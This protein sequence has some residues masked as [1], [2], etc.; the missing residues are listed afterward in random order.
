MVY[1]TGGGNV[2]SPTGGVKINLVPKEGGNRFSGSLFGGYEGSSLQSNNLTPRL[3]AMQVKSVDK[4][5]TYHDVD[6]TF[7]GPIKKDKLWFFGSGR[8]FTVDKPIAGTYV[9]DGTA[10]H[11]RLPDRARW[12][13]RHAVPQGEIRR[14]ST[15]RCCASRGGEPAQQARCVSIGCSR[16]AARR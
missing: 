6:L 2:D 12:Q 11:R 1:Q 9:S 13:G 8:L 14:A 5:G 3:A 7:G 16:T 4:I 15:A 10:A